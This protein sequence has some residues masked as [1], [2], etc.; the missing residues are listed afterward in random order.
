MH[1]LDVSGSDGN[2]IFPFENQR[3]VFIKLGGFDSIF[4]KVLYVQAQLFHNPLHEG[5]GFEYIQFVAHFLSHRYSG[6]FRHQ[7]NFTG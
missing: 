4:L 5:S 6:K 7:G 2:G 3:V 1:G